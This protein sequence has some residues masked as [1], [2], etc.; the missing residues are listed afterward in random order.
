MARPIDIPEVLEHIIFI[1][2]PRPIITQAGPNPIATEIRARELSRFTLVSRFWNSVTTPILWEF[3]PHQ[4]P[5]LKLLPSDAWTISSPEYEPS[6][7]PSV[8]SGVRSIVAE[9]MEFHRSQSFVPK[10]F[11]LTRTLKR[12]DWEAVRR[13]SKHVKVLWYSLH[14]CAAEALPA[15]AACP[16]EFVLLPRLERLLLATDPR[17]DLSFIPL[18][19]SPTIWELQLLGESADTLDLREI[20]TR[21]PNVTHLRLSSRSGPQ[22]STAEEAI[23]LV[24]RLVCF[25]KLTHL[26]L[27]TAVDDAGSL[28]RELDKVRSLTHLRLFDT[29]SGLFRAESAQALMEMYHDVPDHSM[30]RHLCSIRSDTEVCPAAAEALVKSWGGPRPIER[31]AMPLGRYDR[32]RDMSAFIALIASH[33]SPSTLTH[34]D[35]ISRSFANYYHPPVM[36]MD[37]IRP[38]S[39]HRALRIVRVGA[40]HGALDFVDSDYEE[41]AQWWPHLTEL[42]IPNVMGRSCTLRSLVAFA[43]HCPQLQKLTLKLDA[44]EIPPFSEAASDNV[45]ALELLEV[46]DGRMSD[47]EDLAAFLIRIFPKLQCARYREEDELDR[48]AGSTVV[49]YSR[50]WK[51]VEA[52]LEER[53][54]AQAEA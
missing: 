38:L 26:A 39:S 54:S 23:S 12:S 17:S 48:V 45:C 43:T 50:L 29:A 18:L 20:A 24:M 5:L 2:A 13:L 52:A 53:A 9:M 32:M 6:P 46:T 15:M 21:C 34:L 41:L 14:G 36:P 49:R 37:D 25:T 42:Y 8:P 16:P 47:P 40:S 4:L 28:L 35:V 19:M 33:C 10:S 30:F 1:A 27:S 31:F 11:R 51:K 22:S 3:L 7:A 44:T